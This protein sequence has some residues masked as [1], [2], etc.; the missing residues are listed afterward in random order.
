MDDSA[1]ERLKGIVDRF[2][3]APAGT[4][5]LTSP[6]SG[7][8]TS[9]PNLHDSKAEFLDEKNK[10]ETALAQTEGLLDFLV[11]AYLDGEKF[12][13]VASR[14]C[15]VIDAGAKQESR[16]REIESIADLISRNAVE[17][18]LSYS[19]VFLL[20]DMRAEL[21]ARKKEL[22]AQEAAFWRLKSRAPDYYARTIALRFAQLVARNTGKK[23]TLGTSRDGSH[24][25]TDFGRALEEIFGILGI[26][27]G[28]RHPAKWAIGQLKDEDLNPPSLS[29]VVNALLGRE[30]LDAKKRNRLMALYS[31][32]SKGPQE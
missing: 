10:V 13:N 9:K 15:R 19:L 8:D 28:F 18:S 5:I 2:G 25:S 4:T 26:G 16:K 23:P 12:D 22:E 14:I 6:Y 21:T 11:S 32:G 20:L 24:P 29:P 17:H 31:E 3:G 30:P 1:L 7:L 27:T